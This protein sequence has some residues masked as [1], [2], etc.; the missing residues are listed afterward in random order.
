M[1]KPTLVPLLARFALFSLLVVI[2]QAEPVLSATYS[3][4]G[5]IYNPP[6]A[7]GLTDCSEQVSSDD[8]VVAIPT[9]IYLT[10]EYCNTVHR[11]IQIR[12]AVAGVGYGPRTYAKIVDQCHDCDSGGLGM[13]SAVVKQLSPGS[14]PPFDV[15]WIVL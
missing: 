5:E 13:T 7:P 12:R 15:T 8:L 4:E 11:R 10:E 6:D 3:G 14:N 9:E 1:Y 2:P